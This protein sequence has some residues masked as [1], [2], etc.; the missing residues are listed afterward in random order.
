MAFS[1]AITARGAAPSA[2][3][4]SP[5]AITGA[6]NF[7]TVGRG[8]LGDDGRLVAAAV[9][10]P[11][12]VDQ[13]LGRAEPDL[14]DQ[15]ARRAVEGVDQLVDDVGE[16]HL[17]AGAMQDQSDEPATDVPRAEVDGDSAHSSLTAFRRS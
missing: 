3:F 8:D 14:L 6:T 2:R 16:H 17:V 12:V 4:R 13:L 5:A 7:S 9:D 1:H 15:V 10:R 11:V